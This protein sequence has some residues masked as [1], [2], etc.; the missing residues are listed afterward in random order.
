VAAFR[1][2]NKLVPVAEQKLK[3]KKAK[4]NGEQGGTE[5]PKA[6]GK[7]GRRSKDECKLGEVS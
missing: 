4:M 2:E 7:R 3:Q 6:K 1:Y 5:L